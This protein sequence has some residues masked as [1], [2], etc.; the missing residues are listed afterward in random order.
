MSKI[1]V[2]RKD[3][4]LTSIH[5]ITAFEKAITPVT[6]SGVGW[7]IFGVPVA[8]FVDN[9]PLGRKIAIYV[10]VLARLGLRLLGHFVVVKTSGKGKNWVRGLEERNKM[11]QIIG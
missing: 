10:D 1:S 11:V 7:Q 5:I 6:T 2:E 8:S 4:S 9:H 3:V